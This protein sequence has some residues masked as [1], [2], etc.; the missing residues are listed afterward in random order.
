MAAVGEAGATPGRHRS[1]GVGYLL[2]VSFL[3]APAFLFHGLS[4]LAYYTEWESLYGLAILCAALSPFAFALA[5]VVGL[6]GLFRKG[7]PRWTRMVLVLLLGSTVA[8]LAYLHSHLR[9]L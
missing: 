5:A 3:C 2:G 8:M 7:T 9:Y 4:I 1:A 6:V